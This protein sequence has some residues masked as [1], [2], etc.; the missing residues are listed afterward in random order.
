MNRLIKLIKLRFFTDRKFR[1]ARIW[2]NREL[3]KYAHLF[4]GDII[5]EKKLDI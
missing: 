2:S 3:K 1:I 4:T 5:L